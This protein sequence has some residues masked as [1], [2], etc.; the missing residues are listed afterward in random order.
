[1]DNNEWISFIREIVQKGND[2]N[3][4]KECEKRGVGLNTLYRKLI[5][6][7][8]VDNKLYKEFLFLHPYK[9][10]DTQGVDF[11][12]LMRESILTG[13]S[14]HELEEKYGVTK[15]TIQRQFAKVQESNYELYCIYKKYVELAK[16]GKDLDYV[17]IDNVEE[18]YILQSPT[19]EKQK[20]EN[21]RNQFVEAIK[22]ANASKNRQL[23]KHYKEQITRINKQI[24]NDEGR[25]N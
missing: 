6:L 12:Q 20:L 15:R 16:Q 9:P 24:E 7:E 8:K 18:G 2:V 4:K 19:T 25:I 21:R 22:A 17:S 1:M 13:I 3:L 10:R 23:S 11:E 5:L 14:Q